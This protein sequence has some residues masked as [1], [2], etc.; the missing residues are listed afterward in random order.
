ML[1]FAA[2][3]LAS[4]CR[5]AADLTTCAVAAGIAKFFKDQ[6]VEERGHAEMFM[7]YQVRCENVLCDCHYTNG[8]TR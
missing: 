5:A 7:E 4:G 6:S 8:R 3:L 2:E 1:P